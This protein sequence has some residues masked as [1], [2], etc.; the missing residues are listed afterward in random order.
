MAEIYLAGGCFLGIRGIF[1]L[2]FGSANYQC[3]YAN[4]QVRN[5][6]LPAD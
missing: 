6:Q 2:N 1:S 3:S 5:D 4:G